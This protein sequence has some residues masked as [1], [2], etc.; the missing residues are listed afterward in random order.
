MS[1]RLVLERLLAFV[2]VFT[3]TSN[4]REVSVILGGLSNVEE[5]YETG[6]SLVSIVSAANIEEIRDFVNGKV[7]KIPG[8]KSAVTCI[9]LDAHKRLR[10][11]SGRLT[12]Q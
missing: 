5:L 4:V 8:I 10:N 3:E 2:N 12:S 1:G 9:V 11:G 6:E 7:R